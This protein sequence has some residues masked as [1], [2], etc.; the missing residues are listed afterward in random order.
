MMQQRQ[1]VFN[2][3]YSGSDRLMEL[4]LELKSEGRNQLIST[5]EAHIR[6]H[7]NTDFH[8]VKEDQ[9]FTIFTGHFICKKMRYCESDS[10]CMKNLI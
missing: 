10:I 4:L 7:F 5:E 1:N 8:T 6:R 3:N 9:S 2:T